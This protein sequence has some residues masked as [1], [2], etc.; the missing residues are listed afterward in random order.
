MKLHLFLFIL[1]ILLWPG[2]LLA[3][4]VE[5]EPDVGGAVIL[6]G[7]VRLPDLSSTA[8]NADVVCYETTSG[9]LTNCDG[10]IIGATGAAGPA[11]A[12]GSAG[13]TGAT[14]LAGPT[15]GTGAPGPTGATGSAGPTGGTG[16][17][18]PTGATGLAGP[19]GATGPT[20]DTNAHMICIYI[21]APAVAAESFDS[22]W[23]APADVTIKEMF[24]ERFGG[25]T[26][27][28]NLNNGG[29]DVH[30]L[31]ISCG[32]NPGTTQANPTG[33]GASVSAGDMIDIDLSVVAGPP[34]A[35][36]VCFKYTFD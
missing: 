25:T 3:Q 22:I 7:E 21:E 28:Y 17:A 12:T 9:Q 29:D 36:S 1:T 4:N 32:T 19:T 35:V 20:G 27:S 30:T 2:M 5:V 34:D 6:K 11:G 31:A 10:S 33:P 23:R 8:T 16:S 18:G 15:G 14:G 13:P 26:V 24:C